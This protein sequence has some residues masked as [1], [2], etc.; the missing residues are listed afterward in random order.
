MTILIALGIWLGG[1][2]LLALL[3]GA[4]LSFSEQHELAE[5]EMISSWHATRLKPQ[6]VK[7]PQEPDVGRGT[8]SGDPA[9]FLSPGRTAQQ[10]LSRVRT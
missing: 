10:L 7:S 9:H 8:W 5:L 2:F 6:Q 1:G 3:L 4:V